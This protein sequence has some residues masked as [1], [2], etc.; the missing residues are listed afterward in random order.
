VITPSAASGVGLSNYTISYVNSA[1]SITPAPLTITA[2]NQSTSY[3]T[4]LNLGTSNYSA[5]GLLNGDTLSGVVLQQGGNATVAGTQN[6]GTYSGSTNGLI[7]SGAFGSAA[8]NYN[9]TYVAGVLTVNPKSLTVTANDASMTYG[10][11]A[12]P[13][14]TYQ[15]VSGLV[16][17]DTLSGA[18]STAAS[19][20]NG[21]AGSAS[22]AG[23][24]TIA[25][26][27]LTAGPNYSI[28]YTPG[29]LTVNQAPLTVT[30]GNQA[31]TYGT[32]LVL[33]QSNL[34]TTGL[35]NGDYVNSATIT[36]SANQVVPGTTNAGTYSGALAVSAA[37]GAGMANYNITYV[38]GNLTVNKAV[39][40][41]TAVSSAQ[42]VGLSD[43]SGYSGVMYSGF[44]NSD[45]V[46]SGALGSAVASVTRTNTA[47]AAG[48][49][50]G[51]L[52]P[53]LSTALQ[54]YTVN[55][56]AGDYTIVPANTLLVQ[57]GTTSTSYSSAPSYNTSAMTAA[58]CTN[59]TAGMNPSSANI[60]QVLASNIAAT[61]NAITV[62]DGNQTTA[63]FNLGAQN[64]VM[65]TSG[66]ISVG[67]YALGLNNLNISTTAVSGIPNY[68]SVVVTGGLTVTPMQLSYSSLGVSGIS[69]VYDGSVYINNQALNTSNAFVA[70]DAVT[71]SAS[72][73]FA[74]KNV[75]SNLSFTVGIAL[76]GA[77][78][79]NYQLNGGSAYSATTGSI[80][81][82]NSVTYTGPA[83]G[84]DWSNP[85]NWT[86]TGTNAIGAIP[87]LSN[88]ANVI[89]PTGKTVVYDNAVA[90]PVTSSIAN[91]GNVNFSLSSNTTVSMPISG[92]GVVTIGGVGVVTLNGV[93][94]YT[95]GTVIN[96]G[97]TLDIA[98]SNAIGTPTIT[99][100]GT[101]INPAQLTIVNGVTLAFLNISGGTTQLLSNVN[102]T[103]AQTYSDLVLT[104]DTTLTTANANVNFLGTIDGASAKTQSLTTN[105]GTGTI[106]IASS[107]GSN[108]R[109][110]AFTNTA[111]T[112]NILADVLTGTSQT[113]NGSVFI[114]DASYIGQTPTVGF[115]FANYSSYFQY[116]TATITST[117]QYLNTNPI[118]VRSLISE[119]PSITFNGAVNDIT[120]NTHTLLVAAIVPASVS[121]S[122]SVSA[123]N[124]AGSINFN[125]PVGASAPL[126]SLNAQVIVNSNQSD[127]ASSYVGSIALVGGVSTYEGQTY[128]AN[129]MSAQALSQPGVVTFAVWDPAAS[130]NYILPIQTVGN[131]ACTAGNC[132]QINLQNPNSVDALVIH[133]ENNFM[134]NAN[135]TGDN[136]WGTKITQSNALGYVAPMISTITSP[137]IEQSPARIEQ[138]P[139]RIEQSPARSSVESLTPPVA[140]PSTLP[141]EALQSYL[142]SSNPLV[143]GSSGNGT[144]E[145]TLADKTTPVTPS[146]GLQ[147]LDPSAVAPIENAAEK[148][149]LVQLQTPQGSI[150]LMHHD[151]QSAIGFTF[152]IPAEVVDL[153]IS[154]EGVDST[155]PLSYVAVMEDGLA[156]PAWLSFSSKDLTFSSAKVPDDVK[157]LKIKLQAIQG[158]REVAHSFMTIS[159]SKK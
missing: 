64:A 112:I 2:G 15:T 20:Y 128:R 39:L 98:G 36:Y 139:A 90:G 159:T 40:T 65:S 56:V 155:K 62:N 59:C 32:P 67:N 96:S 9:I 30:A 55:Y 63:T 124:G 89:I 19:A 24:Y 72:G 81:Q 146:P 27:T 14:L 110:N 115:L 76:S 31:T 149:V 87:D 4:P 130:V 52:A 122:S 70:G 37:S 18:L 77:D 68:S 97:A 29:T 48:T 41:V 147:S 156:L 66:N 42:F 71:A 35:L 11:N 135:D 85:A 84:G 5:S 51:V 121:P 143:S 13:T 73:S 101:S 49:Y 79:V 119:D 94:S 16:N 111:A 129:M 8:S 17:G 93:N 82:L 10:A 69:K 47:T 38:P 137:T 86:T 152:T 43:P 44:Q 107:V 131:S 75:G 1:L 22:N 151:E 99:S 134:F 116:T 57:A 113:Y 45:S 102:T 58:Y 118:Y 80:T 78:A 3:G 132:G 61:G 6:A 117:I 28:S 114:G 127:S 91:S 103:G 83:S 145:I 34:A 126:Y 123:I 104:N 74:T 60:V 141:L 105:A 157:S 154:T 142:L 100:N 53:S 21:M 25:Q 95:G 144:V 12:L 26:G 33:S 92:S 7:A 106:T 109:L 140:I 54:N 148:S 88:V 138:S 158:G 108:A 133:G 23:T 153:H 125:A 136:N 46:T 150:N 50:N 120:P